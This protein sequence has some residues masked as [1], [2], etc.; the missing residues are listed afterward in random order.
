[1]VGHPSSYSN[2]CGNELLPRAASFE[3]PTGTLRWIMLLGMEHTL[4]E[5]SAA[6]SEP[7]GNPCVHRR[8]DTLFWLTDRLKDR[9]IH[10][11][12]KQLGEPDARND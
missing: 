9:I 5:P 12:I 1:M 10:I 2:V 7:R 8:I 4:E 6:D 11:Y 3:H